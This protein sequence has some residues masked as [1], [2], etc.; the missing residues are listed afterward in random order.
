MNRSV[1]SVVLSIA[2]SDS[3]GGAGIQGDLKTISALGCFATTAITAVTV[4]NTMGVTMIHPIPAS[5][6]SAQVEAV[7]E[8]MKP[9]AIKIGMVYSAELAHSL[10][11][12]LKRYPMIP[13]VCDPVMVATSGDRL[14]REDT[15]SVLKEQLF[16][17]AQLVTPNLDEAGILADMDIRN[18]K[19]MKL[20]AEKILLFGSNAVLIKGGH[21]KG[22][23]LF[24]VYL[25]KN[26]DHNV[27]HSKAIKTNNT[28]GTGCSLSSAIAS[29]LALGETMIDAISK[30]RIYLQQAI[31]HGKDVKTGDGHGPLNHFFDPEKLRIKK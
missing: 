8:D 5:I 23:D 2:G 3:G 1:Y 7:I 17:L 12:L 18:V 30:A 15:I 14:M 11:C 22:E 19:D 25:N 27:F 9:L 26:G 20:A 21:L 31:A 10:V 29:Y 4:Q 24:D 13:V 16:P 28:H 6:V